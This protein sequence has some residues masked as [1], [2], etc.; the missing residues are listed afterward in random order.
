MRL[1]AADEQVEVRHD[2]GEEKNE[3]V[4]RGNRF[5]DVG[6][7]HRL[8]R[9]MADAA[10]AAHERASHRAERGHRHGI[11]PGAARQ[12]GTRG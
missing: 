2:L 7:F 5:G 4:K 12:A 10:F 6:S 8:G 1:S 9:V 11:V 3:I